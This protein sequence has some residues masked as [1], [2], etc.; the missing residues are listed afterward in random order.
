M[1]TFFIPAIV[2]IQIAVDNYGDAAVQEE[3][4][5]LYSF[6]A[7][8]KYSD[9]LKYIKFEQ[10]DDFILAYCGLL[11]FTIIVTFLAM[12]YIRRLLNRVVEIVDAL[13][14]TPSDFC[15]VGECAEFSDEC[16]YS[17]KSIESEVRAGIKD[18]FQIDEIEYVNVAYDIEDIFELLSKE[19]ELL[20]KRELIKWF[21]QLQNWDEN[22]YMAE[23]EDYKEFDDWPCER[24][25]I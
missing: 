20:K 24:K 14:Y 3:K 8:I 5:S 13:S 2:F 10:R 6:G 16:N 1:I 12:I 21:M 18:R 11:T 17:I 19:R 15:L 9:P 25:G 4:I 22:Q 23:I 7:L